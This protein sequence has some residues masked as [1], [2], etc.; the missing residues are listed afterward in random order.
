MGEFT[1]S[2]NEVS[3]INQAPTSPQRVE[4]T[5]RSENDLSV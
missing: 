5:I 4:G 2:C 3:T 1:N